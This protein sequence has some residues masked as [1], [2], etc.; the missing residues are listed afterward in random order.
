LIAK[1]KKHA[2]ATRA[3]TKR[4][5]GARFPIKSASFSGHESF[6]LRF[7]WLKKGF[8]GLAGNPAFF[9]SPT[10]MVEMGTG[11][12]MVRAIRHWGIAVQAWKEMQ[13]SRGRDLEATTFGRRLLAEPDGW[14]P[15]LEDQATVWLLHWQ[16]VTNLY[17]ATTWAWMFSRPG[18]GRFSKDEVLGEL[19]SRAVDFGVKKSTRSSL[20]RDLDVFVNTYLR[21]SARRGDLTEDALDC[22][23]RQLGLLRPG[24]ER[25]SYEF[26]SG[27]RESLPNGVFTYAVLDFVHRVSAD[28]DQ[29][30]RRA[31]TYSMDSLM[32]DPLSPGRVFQLGEEELAIRLTDV[33][34]LT[35]DAIRF[36][37]TAGLRQLIVRAEAPALLTVL[38][39]VYEGRR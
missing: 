29:R 6:P 25:G 23:L 17:R 21:T 13:G 1:T 22:P 10:A 7:S 39:R 31:P 3:A 9:S 32:Y 30:E 15:F 11:K 14:D 19:E 34:E 12:N 33:S 5:G 4:L 28:S 2:S 16:I 8:D 37:E 18:G 26:T 24:S 20:K 27:R 35:D 36:D 38:D